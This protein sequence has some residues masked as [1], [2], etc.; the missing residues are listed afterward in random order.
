MTSVRGPDVSSCG[1]LRDMR[2]T[3]RAIESDR[4]RLHSE[5]LSMPALCLTVEQVARLLDVTV[6]TAS[7][8]LVGLESEAAVRLGDLLMLRPLT[9]VSP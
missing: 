6:A 5:F 1:T 4:D 3:G 9:N 8:L 7:C 2:L